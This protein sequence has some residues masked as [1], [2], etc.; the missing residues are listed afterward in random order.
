[1]DAFESLYRRYVDRIHAFAYRR[2][3]SQAVADDV[4]QAC[5][6]RALRAI[7]SFRWRGGGFGPWLFRIASNELANHY[8]AAR[9]TAM[10]VDEPAGGGVEEG[11]LSTME[12]DR[13]RAAVSRLNP[14]YQRALSLRYLAGLSHAEA[15][16]AMDVPKPVFAVLVHR[17]VGALRRE[18]ERTP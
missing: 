17:A 4:T 7:T 6:E 16:T 18:L 1:M 9:R 11:V 13:V 2:A 14:R 10:I 8:R 15:S 3:G 5:F 12:A